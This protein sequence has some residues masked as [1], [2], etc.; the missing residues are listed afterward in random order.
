MLLLSPSI[1]GIAANGIPASYEECLRDK[2]QTSEISQLR[3]IYSLPLEPTQ[4]TVECLTQTEAYRSWAGQSCNATHDETGYGLSCGQTRV[5]IHDLPCELIFYSP[6]YAFPADFIECQKRSG[7]ISPTY[8]GDKICSIEIELP[9]FYGQPNK[10]V[11]NLEVGQRLMEACRVQGGFYEL[12]LGEHPQCYAAF[13]EAMTQEA[14]EA[15]R[16][17]WV[18]LPAG[19]FRCMP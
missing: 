7:K 4:R 11:V 3:C 6:E 16:H 12:A 8:T 10:T 1:E 18:Q 13:V 19:A 9:P 2:N 17:R 15:A 5:G 14:C